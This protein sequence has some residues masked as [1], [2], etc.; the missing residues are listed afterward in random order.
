MRQRVRYLFLPKMIIVALFIVGFAATDGLGQQNMTAK[1]PHTSGI[2]DYQA[3]IFFGGLGTDNALN[4]KAVVTL[5]ARQM[6][7]SC[8]PGSKHQYSNS[9][10][11]LCDDHNLIE[12]CVSALQR[13]LIKPVSVPELARRGLARISERG[14][15]DNGYECSRH[16]ARRCLREFPPISLRTTRRLGCSSFPEVTWT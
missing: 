2:R 8:K 10:Y 6:N 12:Q 11:H 3:L 15:G 1:T 9:N 5:L 4:D 14:Y 13:C 7:I 16:R